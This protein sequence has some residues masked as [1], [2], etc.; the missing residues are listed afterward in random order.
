MAKYLAD[1]VMKTAGVEN[2]E[3]VGSFVGSDMEY[4]KVKHP[5]FDRESLVKQVFLPVDLHQANHV[6]LGNRVDL[7]TT[8]AGVDKGA[9][10]DA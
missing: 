9:K 3:L 5:L 8:E 6:V 4:V 7:A 1:G 10:S 2:Y